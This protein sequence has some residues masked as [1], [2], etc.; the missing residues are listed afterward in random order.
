VQGEHSKRV[1]GHFVL[2]LELSRWNLCHLT[3][4]QQISLLNYF[5]WWWIWD[6]GSGYFNDNT[7]AFHQKRSYVV[8][9]RELVDEKK[10]G[11]ATNKMARESN[12]KPML[13]AASLSI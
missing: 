11:A 9:L 2:P 1:R 10:N 7:S 4:R 3:A 8:G 5:P 12:R 13:D 6:S